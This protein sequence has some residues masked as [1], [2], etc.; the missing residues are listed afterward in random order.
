MEKCWKEEQKREG[1][2]L[3]E[4]KKKKND[5]ERLDTTNA[6][7]LQ[8]SVECGLPVHT[9]SAKMCCLDQNWADER[10]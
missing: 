1:Q 2:G 10:C 7:K 4:W 6:T 8:V 5:P 3:E 9:G